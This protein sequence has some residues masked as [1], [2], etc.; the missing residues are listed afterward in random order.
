MKTKAP[1]SLILL[2]A[3][4]LTTPAAT[5]AA[6]KAPRPSLSRSINGPQ[7]VLANNHYR[8]RV[9]FTAGKQNGAKLPIVA[10]FSTM[11]GFVD[12]IEV[13]IDGKVI[14][15]LRPERE[16]SS[17]ELKTTIDL[18]KVAPGQHKITLW[19]WQGREGFQRFHGESPA[20][21]ITR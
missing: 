11:R 19:A 5:T 10:T 4:L 3:A 18:S 6:P 2:A 15:T 9:R 14:G 12:R 17:G 7:G 16:L 20:L 8:P 1:L 13:R 21:K